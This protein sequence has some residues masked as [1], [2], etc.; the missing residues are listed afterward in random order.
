M[1]VSPFV[2]IS[3]DVDQ[4]HKTKRK[5]KKMLARIIQ[6]IYKHVDAYLF[7]IELS[8]LKKSKTRKRDIGVGLRNSL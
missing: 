5:L 1:P 8:S 2:A 3:I 7:D 6:K 4:S